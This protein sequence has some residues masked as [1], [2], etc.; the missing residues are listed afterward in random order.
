MVR[1]AHRDPRVFDEPLRY[2]PTRQDAHNLLD[3]GGGIYTCLGK[4]V[5]LIEIQEAIAELVSN[6]PNAQLKSFKV[7][8]NSFVD[9]I[10]DLEVELGGI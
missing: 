7:N 6:Y 8:T 3:F 4:F 1:A 5:A 9:E 2:D 10:S